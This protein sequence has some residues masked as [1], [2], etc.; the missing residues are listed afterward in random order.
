[1]RHNEVVIDTR[2]IEAG[3][4]GVI[5][6]FFHLGDLDYVRGVR[7]AFLHAY[8]LAADRAPLLRLDLGAAQ[9]FSLEPGD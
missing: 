8:G 1:M 9:P 4:P 3:L 7:A 6:A 2:S 5:L